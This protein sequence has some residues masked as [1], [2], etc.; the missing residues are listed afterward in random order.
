MKKEMSILNS[1]S[2]LLN[3]DPLMNSS[4]VFHCPATDEPVNRPSTARPTRKV[5]L[6]CGSIAAR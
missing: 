1:G 5:I 6:R 3:A 4:H 2:V